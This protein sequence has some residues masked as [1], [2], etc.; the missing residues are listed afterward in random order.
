MIMKVASLNMVDKTIREMKIFTAL[1]KGD[2]KMWI[3]L[4][5]VHYTWIYC[6]Y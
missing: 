6:K 4:P 5:W 2:L 1:V 3:I